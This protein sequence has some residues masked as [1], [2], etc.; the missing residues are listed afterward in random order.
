MFAIFDRPSNVERP[1]V[2]LFLF[3]AQDCIRLFFPKSDESR[4]VL[5]PALLISTIPIFSFPNPARRIGKE[6]SLQN[7]LLPMSIVKTG[8]G[9]PGCQK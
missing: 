3:I 7:T 9:F 2:S 6:K 1:I 4:I 8:W 5:L